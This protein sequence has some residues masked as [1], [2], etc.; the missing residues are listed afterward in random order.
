MCGQLPSRSRVDQLKPD[1]PRGHRMA[2]LPLGFFLT[3]HMFCLEFSWIP[4]SRGR[5]LLFALGT[6]NVQL[7]HQLSLLP[8]TLYFALGPDATGLLWPFLGLL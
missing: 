8:G 5:G 7:S 4:G 2:C 6:V 3:F 1:R